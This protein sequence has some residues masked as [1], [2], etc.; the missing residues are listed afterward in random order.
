MDRSAPVAGR[1]RH[2]DAV[3]R[4]PICADPPHYLFL[5]HAG[6]NAVGNGTKTSNH[7][8]ETVD[9]L[10]STA[11]QASDPAARSEALLG[12]AEQVSADLPAVP[13]FWLA[14]AM[15]IRSDLEFDG[16]TAFRSNTPWADCGF[17]R[18]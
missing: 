17:S 15:A 11:L 7:R 6:E 2:P 10:L 1:S 13:I 9:A 5:F 16:F 3:L 18:K 8:N 12:V 14:S 4:S